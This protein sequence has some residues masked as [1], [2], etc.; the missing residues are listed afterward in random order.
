MTDNTTEVLEHNPLSLNVNEI[1]ISIKPTNPLF[2]FDS[3]AM[4][5][6]TPSINLLYFTCG[7]F[8]ARLVPPSKMSV[9]KKSSFRSEVKLSTFSHKIIYN[10]LCKFKSLLFKMKTEDSPR[11]SFLSSWSYYQTLFTEYTQ[12]VS[13][14]GEFQDWFSRIENS[15]L[16]LSKNETVFGIIN[17]DLT[18]FSPQTFN[19]YR[20]VF[21]LRK[22]SWQ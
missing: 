9:V 19:H 18:L 20:K 12:A 14:W 4:F 22:C 13:F 8:N 6:I 5:I 3:S 1:I 17:K 7:W 11:C 16:F 21:P 10:I 15:R 2:I